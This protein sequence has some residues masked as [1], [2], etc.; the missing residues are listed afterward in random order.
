[1]F[2]VFKEL[3][4]RSPWSACM[5]IRVISIPVSV[6]NLLMAI[7]PVS[8]TIVMTCTSIVFAGYTGLYV[9]IGGGLKTYYKD[10]NAEIKVVS[11]GK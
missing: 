10:Y 4:V 2:K 7:L 3:I 11:A 1:M 5:L 9:N 6:K 8:M